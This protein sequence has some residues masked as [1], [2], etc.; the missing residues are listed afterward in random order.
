MRIDQS[1]SVEWPT[2]RVPLVVPALCAELSKNA[3]FFANPAARRLAR[4]LDKK[5]C[6]IGAQIALWRHGDATI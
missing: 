2:N 6:E 4:R 3:N 1:N 5:G